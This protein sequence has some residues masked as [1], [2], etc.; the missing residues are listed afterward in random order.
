LLVL[1]LHFI[2]LPARR[3]RRGAAVAACQAPVTGQAEPGRLMI[4][5]TRPVPSTARSAGLE[6]ISRLR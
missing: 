5:Q 2:N 3:H 4:V 1:E 6:A